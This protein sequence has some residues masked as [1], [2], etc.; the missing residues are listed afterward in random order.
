[1]MQ[2][3]QT[4]SAAVSGQASSGSDSLRK[5]LDSLRVQMFPEV[6]EELEERTDAVKE[7]IQKEMT[8]G[9]IQVRPTA[10]GAKDGRVKRRR[11]S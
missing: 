3:G 1:M 9:P 8:R 6:A 11:R 4:I 10:H 5:Q 7:L 2:Q